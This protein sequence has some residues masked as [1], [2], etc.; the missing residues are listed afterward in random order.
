MERQM[1]VQRDVGIDTDAG[2][3]AQ[4]SNDDVS[5]ACVTAEW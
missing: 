5:I 3:A 1:E 2:D 4:R